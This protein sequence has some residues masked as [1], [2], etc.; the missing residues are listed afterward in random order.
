MRKTVSRDDRS[1]GL[2]GIIKD[3]QV[4]IHWLD[5]RE[6]FSKIKTLDIYWA[7]FTLGILINQ[8]KSDLEK[9]K[10]GE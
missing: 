6:D 10:K 9:D 3:L 7:I 4:I 8:Y 2:Q 5:N 1:K